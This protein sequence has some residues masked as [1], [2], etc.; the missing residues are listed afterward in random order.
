MKNRNEN[1]SK[2]IANS[3]RILGMAQF[4]TFGYP[5]FVKGD[6]IQTLFFI[7]VYGLLEYFSY[8]VLKKE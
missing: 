6:F 4:V 7:L 8:V 2:H 1:Q 5:A 3:L